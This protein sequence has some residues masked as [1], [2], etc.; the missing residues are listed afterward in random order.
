[1]RIKN[2]KTEGER[3]EDARQPAGDRGQNVC[4]LGA[5]NIFCHPA[6]KSRSKPFALRSLHQ[7]D[8]HHEHRYEPLQ[9]Q[10]DVDHDRHRDGQ[11]GKSRRFVHQ[12]L[13]LPAKSDI[14]WSNCARAKDEER[15]AVTE[16]SQRTG[17]LRCTHTLFTIPKPNMIIRANEPL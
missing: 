9:N 17:T 14:S 6:P 11:Y 12:E 8:K 3:E 5:E 2:R 16:L 13:Q 4:R 7:D 10:Q 15:G 1:M